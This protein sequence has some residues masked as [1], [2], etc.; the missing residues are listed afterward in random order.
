M[1]SS[2][3]AGTVANT[4]QSPALLRLSCDVRFQPAS[5]AVD[6]RHTVASGAWDRVDFVEVS[7]QWKNPDFLLKNPD[8]LIRNPDF[9]LKSVDFII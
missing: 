2:M 9:L 6:P 7:F 1:H 3:H 5:D 8:L 4:T